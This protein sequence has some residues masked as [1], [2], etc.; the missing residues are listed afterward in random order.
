MLPEP[1]RIS[2]RDQLRAARA[3]ALK[4]AEGSREIFYCLERFAAY[5]NGP[6]VGLRKASD[7]MAQLASHS[8]LAAAVPVQLK[9]LHPTFVALYQR[10]VEGRNQAAHEGAFARNL[11]R[12]AVEL[13]LILEDALQKEMME[14]QHFM[15]RD[16]VVAYDWEPI[17][18]VRQ[19][20]LLNAF[21]FLPV[22]VGTGVWFL[23][24]DVAIAC[25]LR[26]GGPASNERRDRLATPLHQATRDG[27]L[28]LTEAT[29]C[30]PNEAVERIIDRLQDRPLLV[31][32]ESSRLLGILTA[33]D[34]L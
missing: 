30:G 29:K 22:E 31:T 9:E 11:T 24:S 33:F 4:N 1:V 23:V 21:S 14:V 28:K 5:I 13:T 27:R 10:V 15:V 32:D 12:H 18:L 25:F 26:S 34:L 8:P 17:S 19:K 3:S 2:F 6:Q 20:L 16:P 7:K